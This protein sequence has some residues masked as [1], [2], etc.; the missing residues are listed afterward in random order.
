MSHQF[1]WDPQACS[2]SHVLRNGLASAHII[3]NNLSSGW[4]LFSIKTTYLTYSYHYHTKKIKFNMWF[5]FRYLLDFYPAFCLGAQC[6]SPYSSY[7]YPTATQC[8]KLCWQS[9]TGSLHP[10]PRDGL[11]PGSSAC[12]SNILTTTSYW[13]L[14]SLWFLH[15]AFG[16]WGW[17]NY[18][19]N[20][21]FMLYWGNGLERKIRHVSYLQCYNHNTF[22]VEFIFEW[23]I[24][25]LNLNAGIASRCDLFEL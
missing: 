4:R 1:S 14:M 2:C 3:L 16:E 5:T 19:R 11:D 25:G 22:E 10:S 6:G 13:F 8:D 20:S 9:V 17:S 12:Q 24:Y 18:A 15:I 23:N 7:F 21:D